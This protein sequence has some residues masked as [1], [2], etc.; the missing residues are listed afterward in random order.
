MPYEVHTPVFDGP[1]DMLLHLILR[2]RVDLYE[3]SLS[4]IVDAYLDELDRLERLDLGVA[5]EFL[6]IAATLLE[7]KSRRL[8]PDN[9]DID[10]DEELDFL[11]GRDL[12]L[13]R[14]VEC[15]TFSD[16]A[17]SLR[18]LSMS[19]ARSYPRTCGPPSET[20]MQR[21]APLEATPE[22]LRVAYL[23][24]ST[25]KPL[26]RVDIAHITPIK[27]TV[28]ESIAELIAELSHTPRTT[29]KDLTVQF[30]ERLDIVVRFLALLEL[31]KQGLVDISQTEAFGD[32]TIELVG[33][34]SQL[35]DTIS[36]DV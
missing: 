26:E 31:F 14:L 6:L 9:R 28:A 13:A 3:I 2:E 27:V 7:L 4:E 10:P 21:I 25:P 32:I 19:A 33:T 15:K 36:L 20:A 16:A 22:D 5:T 29:F 30:V 17:N 11:D 23:R 12:L 1:F 35:L 34:E 18:A 24:A 8:L